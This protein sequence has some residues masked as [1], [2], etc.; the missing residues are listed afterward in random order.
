MAAVIYL[1]AKKKKHAILNHHAD[2]SCWMEVVVVVMAG[3]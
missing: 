3:R 1:P 2:G